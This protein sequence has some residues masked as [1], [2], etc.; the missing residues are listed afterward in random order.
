MDGIELAGAGTG[1]LPLDGDDDYLGFDEFDFAVQALR[2][3][4]RTIF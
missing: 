3:V 4:C 1:S 2:S